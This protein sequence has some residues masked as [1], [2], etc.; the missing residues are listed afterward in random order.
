MFRASWWACMFDTATAAWGANSCAAD[1][2]AS[3]KALGRRL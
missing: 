3:S 1:R 2:L